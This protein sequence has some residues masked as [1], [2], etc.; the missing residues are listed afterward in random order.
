MAKKLKARKHNRVPKKLPD[1][2]NVIAAHNAALNKF[3]KAFRARL[4][5]HEPSGQFPH[6]SGNYVQVE[7]DRFDGQEYPIADGKYRVEGSDW[8]FT[9]EG[10]GFVEA[11][12]AQPPEYGGKD[13]I[14]V[15]AAQPSAAPGA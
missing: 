13:V 12:L 11:E 8:I 2:P 1:D 9:F 10:G 15:P 5:A 14:S 3:D 6:S 7:G 4:P